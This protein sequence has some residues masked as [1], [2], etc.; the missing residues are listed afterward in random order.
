MAGGTGDQNGVEPSTPATPRL[1][2]TTTP[3]PT[4]PVGKA[5]RWNEHVDAHILVPFASERLAGD[6]EVAAVADGEVTVA[7]VRGPGDRAGAAVLEHRNTKETSVAG[8]EDPF[9]DRFRLDDVPISLGTKDQDGGTLQ[10]IVQPVVRRLDVWTDPLE[11][12]GLPSLPV[13]SA[14]DDEEAAVPKEA[15]EQ[16]RGLVQGASAFWGTIRKRRDSIRKMRELES[17]GPVTLPEATDHAPDPPLQPLAT[18]HEVDSGVEAGPPA[19]STGILAALMALQKEEHALSDNSNP[20]SAGSSALPTPLTSHDPSPAATPRSPIS[21][22][23]PTSPGWPHSAHPELTDDDEEY[24]RERFIARLR[25]KRASKNA[26]HHASASVASAG[27]HAAGAAIGWARHPHQHHHHHHGGERG[28]ATVPK[29]TPKTRRA[30][31]ATRSQ[32]SSPSASSIN[33]SPLQ[34]PVSPSS[35]V[36][37][38]DMPPPAAVA[39]TTPL[40]ST[41]HRSRSAASLVHLG[42]SHTDL[43]H[44]PGHHVPRAHSHTTLS[45]LISAHSPPSTPTSPTPVGVAIPHRAKLTSELSKRVR[46]LGDRLGLELETS[47]TRPDAAQSGAGVFGG[48]VLST[49]SPR[50]AILLCRLAVSAADSAREP[51]R[52]GF[53]RCTGSPHRVDHRTPREPTRISRV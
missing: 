3:L 35:A 46:R 34:G 12:E 29:G 13:A 18:L 5:V 48:L 42:S 36:S 19:P 16:A 26:L 50:R 2:A 25:E 37:V 47:R 8:G 10:G 53:S 32:A 23:S 40:L 11:T 24:E 44:S 31:S 7:E 20:A 15:D 43:P 22:T 17:G 28:R 14:P 52:A 6:S 41:Q 27:R 33:V 51:C 9:S 1:S 45:R 49:V 38:L 39:G 4:P 21:P 30:A